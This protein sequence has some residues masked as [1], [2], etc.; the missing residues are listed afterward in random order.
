MGVKIKGA[1]RVRRDFTNALDEVALNG[2]PL[3]I[4]HRGE[5]KAVLIGYE[6]F[7]ALLTKL[8]EL[9]DAL[10]LHERRD[11]PARPLEEFLSEV[12]TVRDVPP[13]H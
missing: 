6:Q 3:Y 12:E 9:E 1:T 8:E 2:E 11:E 13:A 4:T 7:E 10:A 5:P